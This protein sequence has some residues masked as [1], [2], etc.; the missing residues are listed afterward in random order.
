VWTPVR[1]QRIASLL[2]IGRYRPAPAKGRPL[3]QSHTATYSQIGKWP[4]PRPS[5]GRRPADK[6][7][8]KA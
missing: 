8:K 7:V 3:T 4:T 5:P 2:S 6:P 1:D